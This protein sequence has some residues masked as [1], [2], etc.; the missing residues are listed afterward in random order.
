MSDLDRRQ[1]KA[2]A[3]ALIGAMLF[4]D[5]KVIARARAFGLSRGHYEG[6][7]SYMTASAEA[8]MDRAVARIEAALTEGNR[9]AP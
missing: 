9:A 2:A 7:P 5:H 6:R 8:K 4:P 1:R 3:L